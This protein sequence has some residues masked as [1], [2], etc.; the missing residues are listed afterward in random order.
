MEERI[1][2]G[3]YDKDRNTRTDYG[4][5]ETSFTVSGQMN[6]PITHHGNTAEYQCSSIP[7]LQ[8]Y[9]T[10]SNQKVEFPFVTRWIVVTAVGRTAEDHDVKIA[11]SSTGIG[12]SQYITIPAGSMSPRIEVKCTDMWV[13]SAAEV[14]IMAGLTN[15]HESQFPDITELDGIKGA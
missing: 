11:F 9:A 13:T 15:V 6:H 5:D 14:N 8:E 12:N 10:A 4:S 3:Y 1:M 2:A 7:W